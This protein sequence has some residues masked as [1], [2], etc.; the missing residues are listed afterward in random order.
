M[1]VDREG[2]RLDVLRGHEVLVRHE[3]LADFERLVGQR[4]E[5][6]HG[7]PPPRRGRAACG[8]SLK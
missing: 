6:D 4:P 3:L 7:E 5:L 8:V 2:V 1:I